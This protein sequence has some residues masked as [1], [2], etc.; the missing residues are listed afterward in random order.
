MVLQW[1]YDM[2]PWFWTCTM[3]ISCF[4]LDLY[5]G[6]IMFFDMVLCVWKFTM[7]FAWLLNMHHGITIA[8]L[9]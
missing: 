4:I 9:A 2:A 5:H 1:F 8:F 3:V 6:I 7:V